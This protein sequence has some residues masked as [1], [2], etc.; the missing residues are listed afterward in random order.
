ML[1]RNSG[2]IEDKVK[3][4]DLALVSDNQ[5]ALEVRPVG[6]SGPDGS[7][8]SVVDDEV[9]VGLQDGNMAGARGGVG[10]PDRFSAALVED[11]IAV[12]LLD[13][14]VLV[15]R[16]DHRLILEEFLADGKIW[17]RHF[18]DFLVGWR[19]ELGFGES[20]LTMMWW[21]WIAAD[22]REIRSERRQKND[23]IDF[24]LPIIGKL[25]TGLLLLVSRPFGA[26]WSMCRYVMRLPIYSI[27]AWSCVPT[28]C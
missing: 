17:N 20:R 26:G 16:G 12:L 13:Q 21:F 4:A 15:V 19:G 27:S 3:D 5:D 25:G 24:G 9:A 7:P 11:E 28:N 6:L 2:D 1:G 14:G 8:L 23:Y 18:W 10:V 22:D